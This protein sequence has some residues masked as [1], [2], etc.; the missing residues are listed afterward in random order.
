M[1]AALRRVDVP[2]VFHARAH[3]NELKKVNNPER[4]EKGNSA[5][6]GARVPRARSWQVKQAQQDLHERILDLVDAK[7]NVHN[8]AA[9]SFF[10]T[11][12]GSFL[13]YM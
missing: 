10:E 2:N 8:R 12:E 9:F 4:K 6:E 1:Q 3:E 13:N 11:A 5:G 7:E